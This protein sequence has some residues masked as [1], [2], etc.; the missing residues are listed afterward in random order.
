MRYFF[1]V[2]CVACLVILAGCPAPQ[3][4]D[5]AALGR[6]IFFDK[7]LSNPP[8]QACASCHVPE[9]GFADPYQAVSHGAFQIRFGFRNAP[10]ITYAA[11]SPALHFDP[12][13]RPGIME[14]MYVGGMFWDGRVDTLEEQA[15][16]PLLNSVEMNATKDSVVAAIRKASYAGLFLRVFGLDSLGDVDKAYD[17]AAHALAEFMRSSEV[18]PFSSK[19]DC[20]QKGQVQLSDAEQNGYA[21]FTGKAKCANCHTATSETEGVPPLFTSFGYQNTGN[22]RNPDNPYYFMPASINPDGENF[23]DLGLGAFLRKS[24]MSEADAAKQD[25]KVKIPSLRNC[26]LT[27]PYM[28]NGGFE[29]LRDVIVFDNTRDVVT[30]YTPEVPQNVHRH[31]PPMMG[32][33]GQLGLTDQEIDDIVAFLQT[34][35]D[36]YQP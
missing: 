16:Q 21:L 5:V 18:N 17:N 8:G 36:G 19:F 7:D 24:G 13:V 2:A 20:S 28:H 12:T 3:P 6:E 31:M 4:G 25:G 35:T 23:V 30:G 32:T 10:S 27:A 26:A 9:S 33:F 11:F 34:L 1:P 15:K 14:G 29:T 22:P